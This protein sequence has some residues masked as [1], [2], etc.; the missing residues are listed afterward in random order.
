[1]TWAGPKSGARSSVSSKL[2]DGFVVATG[3]VVDHAEVHPCVR[4]HRI[5]IARALGERERLL[6]PSHAGEIEGIEAE[7]R[8][9]VRVQLDGAL[10]MASAFG[11]IPVVVDCDRRQG[12]VRFRR[13]CRRARAPSAPRLCRAGRPRSSAG[14]HSCPA[15]CRYRRGR[16]TRARRKGPA[17]WLCENAPSPSRVRRRYPSPSDSARAD[18]A[19]TPRRSSNGVGP[20]R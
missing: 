5:Q 10:E 19:R 2:G 17:R 7:G 8:L 1:M 15:T 4:R 11:P 13:A 3:E 16:C 9:V 14:S 18:S 6:V 20:R 12:V